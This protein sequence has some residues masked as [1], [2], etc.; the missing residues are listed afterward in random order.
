MDSSQTEPATRRGSSDLE[1]SRGIGWVSGTISA[2]FHMGLRPSKSYEI[3]RGRFSTLA[4]PCRVILCGAQPILSRSE[5]SASRTSQPRPAMSGVDL[6]P[7]CERPVAFCALDDRLAVL[8]EEITLPNQVHRRGP[9]PLKIVIE[10]AI[11][12]LNRQSRIA[13]GSPRRFGRRKW[14]VR[15]QKLVDVA[16]VAN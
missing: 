12:L 3:R 8:C 2:T 15:T 1:R 13:G 16:R 9:D 10:S 11:S 5:C 4:R 7:R 14:D 6:L